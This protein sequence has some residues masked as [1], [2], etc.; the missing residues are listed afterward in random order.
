MQQFFIENIKDL[1]LDKD[2]IRQC[3]QVLRMRKDELIR[4]VDSKGHGVMAKFM[5]DDLEQLE[6]VE[7]LNFKDKPYRLRLVCALIRSERLEWL[8]Q[9]ATELGVDEIILWSARHGVVKEFG[10]KEQRKIERFQSIVKEASEQ[11][12][13]QS[14]PVIKGVYTLN[15]LTGILDGNTYVADLGEHP[16]LLD[17]IQIDQPINIITGPEGGFSTD[18]RDYFIE[19][20]YSYVSL[21]DNVLRAETAGMVICNLVDIRSKIHA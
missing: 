11:A 14:I 17:T 20:N 1:K 7:P 16:Y 3:K 4:V 5:N 13:R 6:Y 18:E 2:Q 12:Y 10:K 15:E 19:Q 21:G 8:L 9:K